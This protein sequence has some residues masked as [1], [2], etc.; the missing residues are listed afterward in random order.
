MVNGKIS[1][2][3]SSIPYLSPLNCTWTALDWEERQDFPPDIIPRDFYLT[4]HFVDQLPVWMPGVSMLLPQGLHMSSA[5]VLAST[6][7]TG[8]V[9]QD[10]ETSL[11]GIR[12][13]WPSSHLPQKEHFICTQWH[14]VVFHPP[15]FQMRSQTQAKK[16]I[17]YHTPRMWFGQD[18]NMLQN[19]GCYLLHYLSPLCKWVPV[20]L[21]RECQIPWSGVTDSCEPL[22]A[23]AGNGACVLWKSSVS[24]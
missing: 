10:V 19:L 6:S 12:R 23:G 8:G 3:L 24:S 22:D 16:H 14:K 7:T 4:T 5:L 20:T 18:W 21:R 15:N 2:N 11:A 1:V 13:V 17:L 9:W